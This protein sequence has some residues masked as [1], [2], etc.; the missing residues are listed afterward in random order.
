[1]NVYVKITLLRP[2]YLEDETVFDKP[3]GPLKEVTIYTPIDAWTLLNHRERKN[4]LTCD[5][6]SEDEYIKHEAQICY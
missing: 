3:T 4:I 2:S 5:F 6:I 1:M